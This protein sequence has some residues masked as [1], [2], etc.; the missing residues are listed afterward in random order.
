M[1]LFCITILT[2]LLIISI[3]NALLNTFWHIR[4]KIINI[5]YQSQ[6]NAI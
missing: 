1:H 5:N 4:Y 2:V 3:L 6:T